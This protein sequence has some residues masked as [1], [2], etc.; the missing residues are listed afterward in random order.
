MSYEHILT[1][2]EDQI[3]TITINRPQVYNALTKEAK[4]EIVQS[5]REAGR[6][7]EV[8][9]I[10]LTGEGKAFCTGQDLNDRTIQA[11]EGPVDLGVTLETEWNPLVRAIKESSKP[12]I[13]AVNGVCAG[14]GVSV[15]LA[16]DLIIAHPQA[17]FISGFTKLGLI[18]DAGSSHRF[19]HALGPQKAFEFF[20]FNQPLMP[21]QLEQVGL[22]NTHAQEP[23]ALAKKWAQEL[24]QLAPLSLAELK[25]NLQNA[26]D[27]PYNQM[28]EREVACQ[29]MLGNSKDY[30]EGL[31]AFFEKRKPQFSGE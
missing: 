23:L 19:S 6:N 1:K 27:L 10:I 12:V 24:N 17:K 15:A 4:L 16:C 30:Q 5:L 7:S 14:A 3:F 20:V 13:A 11:K 31:S 18:P 8:R 25:K 9:S 26:L 22:I 29:R 28:L 21:E 2:T